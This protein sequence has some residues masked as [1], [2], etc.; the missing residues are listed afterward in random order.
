MFHATHTVFSA[1]RMSCSGHT[2][3]H[4][5]N[6]NSPKSEDPTA[7]GVKISPVLRYDVDPTATG[8]KISAVLRHDAV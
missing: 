3:V 7:T 6:L 4:E 1:I 2:V 5:T 8:V